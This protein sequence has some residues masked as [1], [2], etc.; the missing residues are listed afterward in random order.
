MKI[1]TYVLIDEAARQEITFS[2]LAQSV[3]VSRNSLQ[4]AIKR[5]SCSHITARKIAHTLGLTLAD[6]MEEGCP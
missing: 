3:G 6:L 4:A 5:G 2:A 1:N